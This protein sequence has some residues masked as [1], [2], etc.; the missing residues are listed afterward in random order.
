MNSRSKRK[1]KITTLLGL[2]CFG[3]FL[4]SCSV[5]NQHQ[6]ENITIDQ[7]KVLNQY[8]PQNAFYSKINEPST[9]QYRKII[10]NKE[11]IILESDHSYITYQLLNH[12]HQLMYDYSFKLL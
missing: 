1:F 9:D 2:G 11:P 5:S 7:T 6:K 12:Q 4:S 8:N 10:N 3:V